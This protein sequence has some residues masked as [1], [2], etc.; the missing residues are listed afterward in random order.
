M[1]F[2]R[3]NIDHSSQTAEARRQAR[4]LAV[5]HGFDEAAAERV[6]IVTTEA[7]TNLLKHA[8]SGELLLGAS[9]VADAWLIDILA[10]DRGP[11]MRTG[12]CSVDGYST[13]GTPGTGLGAMLRMSAHFDVYSQPGAG[14]ALFAQVSRNGPPS[15]SDPFVYGVQIAKPGEDVCGDQWD[16]REHR[17]GVTIVVADGLGHGPDACAA[18]RAATAALRRTD[19]LSPKDLVTRMHESMRHTRGAAIGIVELGKERRLAHFCGLGNITGRIFEGGA[20]PRSMVSTNGTAGV[21]ARVIREFSYPWPPGAAVILHSDGLSARW[22]L[23]DYPGLL[24]HDPGVIAGVLIRDH[25]RYTDDVTVV[26]VK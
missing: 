1:S 18:A 6:A 17:G 21:E 20:P 15:A 23:A 24:A 12:A 3:L 7:A 22:D 26:V 14:T 10:L 16:F 9:C 11:G 19:D 4:G 25:C 2:V 13:S 5:Q 8:G